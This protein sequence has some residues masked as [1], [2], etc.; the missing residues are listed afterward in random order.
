MHRFANDPDKI[1]HYSNQIGHH[2][3]SEI[4][5]QAC[6]DLEYVPYQG[7]FVRQAELREHVQRKDKLR[8][9]AKSAYR[10]MY[11]PGVGDEEEDLAK[12]RNVMQELFPNMPMD[13]IRDTIDRAW[14]PGKIG[15][16]K[17]MS[18]AR[19]VQL[20]VGAHIRHVYT[21][22]DV[23]LKAFS[24]NWARARADVE[25]HSLAKMKEW[26]GDNVQDEE[27][28]RE[29]VTRDV[30]DLTDEIDAQNG[31]GN[32]QSNTINLISEDEE[33]DTDNG[34][35]SDSPVEVT[36][37]QA[38]DEDLGAESSSERRPGAFGDLFRPRSGTNHL[39]RAAD[40][41]E[42]RPNPMFFEQGLNGVFQPS[43]REITAAAPAGNAHERPLANYATP[44]RAL[45]AQTRSL[46]SL[47]EP[48][49]RH[50]HQLPE[51]YAPQHQHTP[52]SAPQ[53]PYTQQLAPAYHLPPEPQHYPV[54]PP[55]QYMPT[56]RL[57]PAPAEYDRRYHSRA[58][59][60]YIPAESRGEV[61]RPVPYEQQY[62]PQ[63][64]AAPPQRFETPQQAA[65]IAPTQMV[66]DGRVFVRV[67]PRSHTISRRSTNVHRS[68]SRKCTRSPQ[69]RQLPLNPSTAHDHMRRHHS[70]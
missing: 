3:K 53:H 44:T 1:S 11:L 34:T 52:Q 23:L 49:G 27:E 38:R 26:R 18:L 39:S 32:A 37:H 4:V 25:P 43:R 10:G 46:L 36:Y 35:A 67:S 55:R 14:Q 5:N 41:S 61:Y 15:A 47:S 60:E 45:P 51:Q 33:S 66:V 29:Y 57:P 54:D 22:Y 16:S 8:N 20:A 21:D 6:E 70:G 63:F 65:S 30:I 56:V 40:G 62:Q 19:R 64:P 24:N 42:A 48:H 7:G 68:T 69:L 2:Y 9:G 17:E 59:A 31:G 28:E 12:V 13:D 58:H 50:Q